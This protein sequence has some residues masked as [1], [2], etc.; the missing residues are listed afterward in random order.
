MSKYWQQISKII[1]LKLNI[2]IVEMTVLSL[3]F[4]HL[5]FVVECQYVFTLMLFV[6]EYNM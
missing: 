2:D 3:T 5:K 6:E 1:S 4:T